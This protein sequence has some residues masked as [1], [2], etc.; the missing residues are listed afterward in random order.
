[1]LLTIRLDDESILL[2][3]QVENPGSFW[4]KEVPSGDGNHYSEAKAFLKL[5]TEM[6]E[7]FNDKEIRIQHTF[8]SPADI[9]TVSIYTASYMTLNIFHRL[10]DIPHNICLLNSAPLQ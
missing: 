9:G 1:M 10:E 4:G 7:Y 6:N 5:H 2:A 3:F 8:P